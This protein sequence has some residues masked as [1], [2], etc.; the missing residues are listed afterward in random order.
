[1]VKICITV[2]VFIRKSPGFWPDV[3]TFPGIVFTFASVCLVNGTV[4]FKIE[5]TNLFAFWV[6]IGAG[7][8]SVDKGFPD[9]NVFSVVPVVIPRP[10]IGKNIVV[11][12]DFMESRL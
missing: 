1:M 4:L 12:N 2:L 11:V 3:L 6:G 9:I 5:K 10:C 7:R 8:I